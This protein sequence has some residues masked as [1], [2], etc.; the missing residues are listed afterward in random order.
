MSVRTSM[1][2]NNKRRC[3][4]FD[5]TPLEESMRHKKEK[6][7]QFAKRTF[8]G[9]GVLA[10]MAVLFTLAAPKAVH[11][12]VATLVQVTNT[13]ANPVPTVATDNPALQPF[14]HTYGVY[15]QFDHT[16]QVPTGKT[17][18]IEQVEVSCFQIVLPYAVVGVT[19]GGV[20]NYTTLFPAPAPGDNTNWGL[21][22]MVRFYADG[23]TTVTFQGPQTG[24]A[25]YCGSTIIGYL[26][27]AS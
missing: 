1:R 10:F 20:Q 18:V 16:F 25:D 6:K 8:T 2:G 5:A 17:L 26:V 19:T 15:G 3:N 24:G 12:I 14:A 4:K 22:Q 23:G 27:N 9:L 21:T 13:S 11:A 7:M